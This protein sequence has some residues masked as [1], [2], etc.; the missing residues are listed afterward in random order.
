MRKAEIKDINKIVN[1]IED[2]KYGLKADGIDQWQIESMDENFLKGQIES[3][4]AYLYEEGEILA[5]GFLSDEKEA[6]YKVW[7]GDFEGDRPLTIHTFAVDSKMKKRGI[8]LK[9]FID[10][11]KFAEKNNFDSLRIDTHEDNFKMRGL[12]NK[13]GFK[14]IGEIYID[15]EGTKKP[16]IC[17]ERYL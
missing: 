13:L 14:K 15:E 3:G 17:Y 9:F 1:I 16:R 12:I 7:E 6:A 10:I 11:I 4:K 5:Y 8:A 2:A